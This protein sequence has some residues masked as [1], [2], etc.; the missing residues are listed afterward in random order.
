VLAPRRPCAI[1]PRVQA[2]VASCRCPLAGPPD[3]SATLGNR[4]F[5]GVTGSEHPVETCVHEP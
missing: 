2:M 3:V 5:S 1:M 4:C